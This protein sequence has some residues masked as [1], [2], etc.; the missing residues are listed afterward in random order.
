MKRPHVCGWELYMQELIVSVMDRFGYP[1]ILFLITLENLFPPIPS[2]IIL[3]FGGF[4]TTY[5]N[6]SV[7][8]VVFF[9]TIGSTLGALILYRVGTLFTPRRLEAALD[10]RICRLLGFKKGDVHKTV[11]WFEKKG[12][13]AVLFGRCVPIVRSLI[14]IPAGM[15]GLKMGSFLLDTIVGSL[16]WNLVLVSAGAFLGA[17]WQKIC[18][19]M[20]VYSEAAGIIFTAAAAA[21]IFW[22]ALKR[23]RNSHEKQDA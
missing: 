12:K 5:T 13:R 8:G 6:M 22:G 11:N 19:W 1:G 3:P 10:N 20:Q 18:E 14:S 17:S 21:F 4:V 16:V 23:L 2:E 15:A 9:S 7:L